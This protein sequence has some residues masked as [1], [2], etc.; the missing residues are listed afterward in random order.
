MQDVW[1]VGG[2][3]GAITECNCSV[4]ACRGGLEKEMKTTHN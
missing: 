4:L 3:G 1:V 2:G